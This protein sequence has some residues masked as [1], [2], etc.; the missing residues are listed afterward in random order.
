MKYYNPDTDKF[1][2]IGEMRS[3]YG[4][5][6]PKEVLNSMGFYELKDQYDHEI[7][8]HDSRHEA[9]VTQGPIVRNGDK[10]IQTYQISK[11]HIA[12]MASNL[13]PQ[14]ILIY[15]PNGTPYYITVDDSGNLSTSQ[16]VEGATA[17]G[18]TESSDNFLPYV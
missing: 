11:N 9:I 7:T 18:Y 3:Q 4:G 13:S 17:S 10:C 12:D 2:G 14:N 8:T 6:L 16:F 5:P 15:S 1:L